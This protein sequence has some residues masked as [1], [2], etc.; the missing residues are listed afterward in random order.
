[1]MVFGLLEALSEIVLILI[2]LQALESTDWQ[3]G[4]PFFDFEAD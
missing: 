3:E 1:M 2:V 4:L